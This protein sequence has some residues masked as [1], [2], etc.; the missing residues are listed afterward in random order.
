MMRTLLDRD[1]ERVGDRRTDDVRPLR[2]RPDRRRAVPDVGDRAGGADRAVRLDRGRVGRVE[3]T[4]RAGERLAHVAV[5]GN[6]SVLE[7]GRVEDV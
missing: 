6:D 2:S 5:L 3:R 7:A 1:V 4:R